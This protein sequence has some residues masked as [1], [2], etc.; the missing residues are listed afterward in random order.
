MARGKRSRRGTNVI[1]GFKRRKEGHVGDK[2]RRFIKG[3]RI[4]C[5]YLN[6]GTDNHTEPINSINGKATNVL[7]INMKSGKYRYFQ[8]FTIN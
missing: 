1:I 4:G 3:K 6:A 5:I 7:L 2:E 8:R